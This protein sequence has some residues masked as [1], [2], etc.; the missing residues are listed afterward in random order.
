MLE[1][2][3]DLPSDYEIASGAPQ[4]TALLE[5]LQKCSIV[6]YKTKLLNERKGINAKLNT[7]PIRIDECERR[8]APLTA[9][10]FQQKK[11]NI[12]VLQSALQRAQ[13]ELACLNGDALL[14][15][16]MNEKRSLETDLRAL[17]LENRQCRAAQ[18]TPIVD[19][20]ETLKEELSKRK[21]RL[22]SLNDSITGMEREI[23]T[24]EKYLHD[25]R[26]KWVQLKKENPV[27]NTDCPTCGQTLP[28]E[29]IKAIQEKIEREKQSHLQELERN[30]GF[31]KKRRSETLDKL[32]QRQK[33]ISELAQECI[34]LE[35]QIDA[36]PE[37]QKPV[38]QDLPHYQ[39]QK[40][41]LT[42]KLEEKAE[43]INRLQTDKQAERDALKRTIDGL[44]EEIRASQLVVSQEQQLT[45]TR[46]RI[47]EFQQEKRA[48]AAKLDEIDGNIDLCDA[49]AQY[50]AN[51]M[52]DRVNS[53]FR[54][55]KFRM[56]R[57]LVNGGLEDCCEITVDGV[58]YPDLNNAMKINVGLDCIT[59]LS[60]HFGVCVPLFV[61]NAEGVTQLL[62]THSQRIRLIVSAE[63]KELRLA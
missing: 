18:N 11:E 33:D 12:P 20:R 48:T 37:P 27:V 61:D 15:Q 19:P 5:I 60:E 57:Q 16:A 36:L 62:D 32:T 1:E 56:F 31:F 29:K 35:E 6:D 42:A 14:S 3:C 43:Q 52:E 25:C 55:A 51:L 54:L 44:Q 9:L 22:E 46:R 10:P 7:L 2:I 63:D 39:E 17:E 21:G 13:T 59:A 38:I 47:E 26:Q 49:L 4:F 28:Q 41:L 40:L 53:N 23:Q 8:I 34:L 30:G 50:K 58:P 45:D 24:G